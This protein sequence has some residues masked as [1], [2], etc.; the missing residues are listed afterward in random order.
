MAITHLII[1]HC[2]NIKHLQCGFS[3][4]YNIILGANGCGKTSLLEAIYLLSVGRSFRASQNKHFIQHHHPMMTLCADL[5]DGTRLGLEKSTDGKQKIKL[6]Q[7]N[8][9]SMAELARCQPVIL[10]DN[11]SFL[12]IDGGPQQRRQFIDWGVFHVE[13]SFYPHWQRY[14]RALKQRNHCLRNKLSETEI[15]IW[16]KELAQAADEVDRLR[17]AYIQQF[18]VVFQQFWQQVM[19]ELAISLT[20]ERGWSLDK[21]L[22]Q[23]LNSQYAR[24]AMLGHT[25]YGAHRA[26]L[27]IKT[28][29]AA[30]KDQLSRGQKKLLVILLRVCQGVLLHQQQ[31]KRVVFL[32]DDLA[33]ELD[34]QRKKLVFQVLEQIQSQVFITGVD[35]SAYAGLSKE[36]NAKMFHVEHGQIKQAKELRDEERTTG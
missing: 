18:N 20:Y 3:H 15:R 32:L 6:N 27:K 25:Q 35:D 24:D 9:S 30:A 36:V 2:R 22:L 31:A 28:E 14:Q 8:Q 23:V 11:N 17:A 4:H 13:H 29:H 33:A 5:D 26:E 19:P 12:L 7:Q 10:L 1:H 34:Q 16:D 21:P